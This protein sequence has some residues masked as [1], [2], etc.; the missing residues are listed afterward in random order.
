V[1]LDHYLFLILVWLV[2]GVIVMLRRGNGSWSFSTTA[3]GS[4][5]WLPETGYTVRPPASKSRG[6]ATRS[7][8][9]FTPRP[10]ADWFSP[11]AAPVAVIIKRPAA[12]GAERLLAAHVLA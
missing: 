12:L 3:F 5:A 9:G 11:F 4:S 8:M 1:Y 2:G 7:Q 10:I 6:A